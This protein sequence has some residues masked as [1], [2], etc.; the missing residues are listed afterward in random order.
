MKKLKDIFWLLFWGIIAGVVFV[1]CILGFGSFVN[2]L[3]T[4]QNAPM[5][6]T[7]FSTALGIF[8]CSLLFLL[9]KVAAIFHN[10]V[11]YRNAAKIFSPELLRFIYRAPLAKAVVQQ[12]EDQI[13]SLRLV[14]EY[15]RIQ[16]LNA[17]VH[18]GIT[19]LHIA[20]ALGYR[21]IC[22]KLI[23]QGAN[24]RAR[25]AQGKTPLD[26]AVRFHQTETWE[27]LLQT[28]SS[29]PNKDNK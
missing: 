15:T 7:L 28:Q 18:E 19:P 20:A 6:A 1:G 25:D 14:P 17:P 3:N 9:F 22:V 4:A 16:T 21:K 8:I 24:P 29:S 27:L 12:R 26:Y 2:W 5:S 23:V 11:T 13:D 10:K